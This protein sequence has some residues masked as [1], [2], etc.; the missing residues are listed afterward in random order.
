MTPQNCID[1]DGAKIKIRGILF[2]APSTSMQN[3][4]VNSDSK[5]KKDRRS[6]GFFGGLKKANLEAEA[7]A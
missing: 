2:F 6:V 1:V 7:R 3:L 4:E 5:L